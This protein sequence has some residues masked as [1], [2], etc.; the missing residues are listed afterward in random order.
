MN[1]QKLFKLSI[2]ILL[3][4]LSA[5]V[6]AQVAESQW[7]FSGVERV[8]AVSDI[9]GNYHDL[10]Y[11]LQQADIVDQERTWTGGKS[12]LLVL[13]D[14]VDRGPESLRVVEYLMN[15]QHQAVKTGGRVHVL[16]GNH[17]AMVLA[18]DLRYASKH[19][20]AG[21]VGEGNALRAKA[22][23]RYLEATQDQFEDSKAALEAFEQRYPP[24][25]FGLRQA[26][27]P[28]TPIGRWLLERPVLVVINDTA[29]VHG[30]L[31]ETIK[32]LATL[33]QRAQAEFRNL[34]EVWQALIEAGVVLPEYPLLVSADAMNQALESA[35]LAG[36]P[37]VVVEQA[38]TL[39]KARQ[40]LVFDPDGPLWYRGDSACSPLVERDNLDLALDELGASRLVVGHTPT[41]TEQVVSRMD[42]RLIRVDT[43]ERPA[44][45]VMTSAVTHAFYADAT[46]PQPVSA[47][48]QNRLASVPLST[49]ELEH[50][51]KSAA[52]VDSEDVGAGVTKPQRLTLEKNGVRLRAIF[53][54]GA[55]PVART[56]R[57]GSRRLL[58]VADRY[59]YDI[60]AYQLDRM[61][62]LNMVPV[63]VERTVNGQRGALQYWVE[64]AM[65]ERQRRDKGVKPEPMCPMAK[66]Y[67]LLEL[68]DRLIYNTDRTQ[69]NILYTPDWRVAL[70]DHTR[71]FRPDVGIPSAVRKVSLSEAPGFARRL[72]ALDSQ[73]LE[74][75]L[76][77][78]L[79]E[80]QL[81]ALLE[82]REEMLQ[83]WQTAQLARK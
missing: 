16:M 23:A 7:R 27:A 45:L 29:F 48:E 19:S 32:D 26:Y 57:L 72:A 38:Q 43:G 8:V 62:G 25:Y 6:D 15:L 10:I 21:F 30:G 42:G 54:T 24:G 75:A 36:Y 64:D 61:I 63:T 20:L 11:T 52:V 12:H 5:R 47:I 67:A 77:G 50:F 3:V 60:A 46:G 83:E 13:G 70:I 31:S 14:S 80:K 55:T 1:T 58:N 35:S 37:T 40:A 18:G 9:H 51:L 49:E 4:A 82:R 2:Y 76:G 71:S 79:D 53:K 74:K 59:V 65:N 33:N 34:L 28:D 56:G 66:Q 81:W 22:Q 68:F 41:R 73:D 78:L 69:E 39:S 44:A 17:E